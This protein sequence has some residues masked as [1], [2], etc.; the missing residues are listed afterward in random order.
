MDFFV[1]V[2]VWQVAGC[3]R[4]TVTAITSQ[5]VGYIVTDYQLL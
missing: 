4:A 1:V 5:H 2:L 3:S